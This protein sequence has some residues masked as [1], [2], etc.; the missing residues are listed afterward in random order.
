VKHGSAPATTAKMVLRTLDVLEAMGATQEPLS[1][2]QIAARVALPKTT[3][4][5]MMQALEQR[6]Y[7]IRDP[8]SKAYVSGPLLWSTAEGAGSR[9]AL[10]AAA[11]PFL[12]RLAAETGETSHLAVLDDNRIVY[13]DVVEPTSRIRAWIT[14][15]EVAPASCVASGKAILA[16][17][18]PAVVAQLLQGP[19]ARCTELS[20]SDP[21]RLKRAFERARRHGY[22]INQ[23]EWEPDIFGLS[24]PVIGAGAYAIAAIGISGPGSRFQGDRLKFL[25]PLVVKQA[26]GLSELLRPPRPEHRATRPR[27][28]QR[29]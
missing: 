21:E 18:P 2:T 14:P 7:V 23:G 28:Q 9:A 16:A 1:L 13:L 22:A 24:A 19:L 6:R 8:V 5:R 12:H 26:G 29:G 15:G 27:R 11:K 10:I 25:A 17:S 4:F 3:V 20:L